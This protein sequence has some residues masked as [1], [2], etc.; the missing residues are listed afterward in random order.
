M[1]LS[2]G[3]SAQNP[4]RCV[5]AS[6]PDGKPYPIPH[7]AFNKNQRNL[8][9]GTQTNGIPDPNMEYKVIATPNGADRIKI[10]LQNNA[11]PN[12]NPGYKRYVYHVQLKGAFNSPDFYFDLFG[13]DSCTADIPLQG[14]VVSTNDDAILAADLYVL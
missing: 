7:D 10:L 1:A 11:A 8:N 14:V 3:I 4:V 13:R 2:P 9:F 12:T 5:V 6:K